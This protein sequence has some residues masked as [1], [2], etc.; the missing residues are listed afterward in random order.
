MRITDARILGRGPPRS[1]RNSHPSPAPTHPDRLGF[2]KPLTSTLVVNHGFALTHTFERHSGA[3][4]YPEVHQQFPQ[5]RPAISK[6]HNELRPHRCHLPGPIRCVR[7]FERSEKSLFK[8]AHSCSVALSSCSCCSPW[9]PV[10]PPLKCKPTSF[11][12]DHLAA[13]P[14]SPTTPI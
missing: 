12:S 9:W 14:T 10:W 4:P 11:P 6:R 13:V 1:R 2:T 5:P 7:H 8:G 3:V